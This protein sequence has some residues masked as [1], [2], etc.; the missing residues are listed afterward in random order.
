MQ[1]ICIRYT[2]PRAGVVRSALLEETADV[3]VTLLDPRFA[4]AHEA[5]LS[6]PIG[7]WKEAAGLEEVLSG[8]VLER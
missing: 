7:D 8:V 4:D 5:T 3:Y 2:E 1:Y 6:S